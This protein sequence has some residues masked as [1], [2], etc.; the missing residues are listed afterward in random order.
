MADT[1]PPPS[2]LSWLNLAGVIALA[3]LQG[4]SA[5]MGPSVEPPAPLPPVD[6]WFVTE[7]D[8]RI[9]APEI[10]AIANHLHD[11]K[12]LLTGYPKTGPITR[13]WV[14]VGGTQPAPDPV[15]PV[16]PQP[17]PP[18][19]TPP[20]VPPQPPAPFPVAGLRVLIVYE[21]ANLLS[22]NQSVVLRSGTIRE[23]ITGKAGDYRIFDQHVDLTNESPL[24]K[25]AMGLPR[26]RLPWLIVGNGVTG[27]QGPL[28][29]SVDATLAIVK[30]Y[31]DA[32]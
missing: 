2:N 29:D 23:Y 21:S 17:V 12:F 7:G 10:E 16:P 20:P 30:K 22:P 14:T 19:P 11:G 26:E 9:E 24:W 32:K 8:L 27:Y 18:G 5:L 3:V 25:N 31:G 28:P 13:L 1:K 4:L 15:P 6:S